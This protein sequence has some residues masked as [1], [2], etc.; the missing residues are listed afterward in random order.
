M[1]TAAA[2]L[3]PMFL[4]VLLIR[5]LVIPMGWLL[6]VFLHSLSGFF[7]LWLLN[8]VSAFTGIFFPINA[9][10]ISVAG[11]LGIPGIGLLTLLEIL[12]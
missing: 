12:L 5:L 3:I 9:V 10:T 6:K 2:L 11:F 1:E 4:G 7:C 8:T